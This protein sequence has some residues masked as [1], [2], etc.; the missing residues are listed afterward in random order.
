M[1]H[2]NEEL[3]LKFENYLI[4]FAQNLIQDDLEFKHD[5]KSKYCMMC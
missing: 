2:L 5:T 4:E 3:F 1:I